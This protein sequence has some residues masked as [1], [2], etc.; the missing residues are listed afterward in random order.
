[1]LH[2]V[3]KPLEAQLGIVRVVLHEFALVEEAA[4]SVVQLFGEVPAA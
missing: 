2:S 3:P 1:V 4:V